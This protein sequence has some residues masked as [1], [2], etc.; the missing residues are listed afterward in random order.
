M[1]TKLILLSALLAL[2][3]VC[4]ACLLPFR[5]SADSK[6]ES[7]PDDAVITYGYL[8]SILEELRLE[9]LEELASAGGTVTIESAYK[10]MTLQKGDVLVLSTDCEAIFRG[11]NAAVIT[12]TC[13][14]GE[15][16]TD[17]SVGTECF[18]GDLLQ[19]GHIY[20]KTNGESRAYIL[21]TGDKASF[22]LRGTYEI[23]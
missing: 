16:L 15:G 13:H 14:E 8:Q 20:Y 3:L 7:I 19:F 11:G 2:L 17:L 18:S 21:I 9:L 12:S 6:N 5:A 22:T 1:K 23:R 10:D 4:G